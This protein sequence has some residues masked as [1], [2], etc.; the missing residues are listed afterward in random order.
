MSTVPGNRAIPTCDIVNRTVF[1]REC[2]ALYILGASV[3][4]TKRNADT[5]DFPGFFHFTVAPV[6][7]GNVHSVVGITI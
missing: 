5:Q 7:L 4:I 1:H 6:H 2:Q 3:K